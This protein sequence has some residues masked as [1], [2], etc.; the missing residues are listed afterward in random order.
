[1]EIHTIEDAFVASVTGFD[2]SSSVN[3][4]A[5]ERVR[6]WHAEYPVL[7]FENQ[8][9]DAAGFVAFARLFGPI[10]IDHHLTRFADPDHPEIIY[11]TNVDPDGNPDPASADRG[12]EWHSDSSYKSDPCAHTMLYALEIPKSGG[13]TLFAD[14]RRAFSELPAPLRAKLEGLSARHQF[15]CGR[16]PGGVIPPTPEERESLPSVIHPVVRQHPDTGDK[17]LYVNPLHTTGILGLSTEESD[18]LLDDLLDR[19]V[20]PRYVHHHQWQVGQVVI[21]DQ[22][23]TLHRGEAAYSMSERRRLM[24]AK[25]GEERP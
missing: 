6:A 8:K 4:A 13:G 16:A 7:V 23:C 15:G 9:L 20:M 2:A 11:V 25:I 22:R 10:E 14:M 21:W 1:M 12:S 3:D 18:I 5:K 24:R 19:S 17:A